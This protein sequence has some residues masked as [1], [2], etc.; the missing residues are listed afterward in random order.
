RQLRWCGRHA[1][2]DRNPFKTANRGADRPR[3]RDPLARER[4]HGRPCHHR[5][6]H[7][8]LLPLHRFWLRPAGGRCRLP[9][10]PPWRPPHPLAGL[11]WA[12]LG[13]DEVIAQLIRKVLYIGVFALIIGNF[14][15][16]ADIVLASFA[17]LGLKASGAVLTAAD[18]MRPGFVAATGFKASRPL[19]E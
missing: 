18:L 17:G 19:L 16:L 6:L 7:R 8:D 15:G 4:R 10:Q 2:A 12:L 13:E 5:P 3:R 1:L 11:F 14:K 9:H